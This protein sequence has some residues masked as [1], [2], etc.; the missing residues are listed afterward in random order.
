MTTEIP[1]S[2]S[3]DANICADHV[4]NHDPDRY[5]CAMFAPVSVRPALMALYA[6]NIELSMVRERVNEPLLGEMRFQWWRD[7]IDGCYGGTPRPE[8]IAG[9]LYSFI[10]KFDPPRQFFDDLINTRTRDLVEEP[11]GDLSDFEEYCRGT[12]ARSGAASS[13]LRPESES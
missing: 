2:G 9:E 7:Q 11:F 10:K 5:L 8:G 1:E 3:G 13:E 12:A 4:R 6:F